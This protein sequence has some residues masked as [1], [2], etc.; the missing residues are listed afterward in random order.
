MNVSNENIEE[1]LLLLADNEL[2][3]AEAGEV[4]AFVEQHAAYKPMLEAYLATHL[5]NTE[6]FIFPDKENLLKQESMVLPLRRSNI[7]PLKLAAAVAVL[8]GVGVAI[9]LMFTTDVPVSQDKAT[10]SKN[11]VI[12]N[13]VVPPTKTT[14]D[15]AALI[16][17]VSKQRNVTGINNNK[18]PKTVNNN[19]HNTVAYTTSS[20]RQKQQV[21]V[22]LANA[23]V[24]ELSID[25]AIQPQ[26]IAMIIETPAEQEIERK[27]LPEWLPVKEENLQGVND[28]VTRIQALKENI[29]EKAQSLKNT[30]FVI[31]LGDKQISIGK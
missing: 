15:T 11:S 25:A 10:A 13:T 21:P 5:D 6:S 29:Q 4:M 30:A 14:K 2:D 1:Y 12:S 28:L 17:Q 8:I 16:A 19:A 18:Q 27:T 20:I 24:N 22:Q 9:T 7:K 26:A 23:P 3:E 31:R